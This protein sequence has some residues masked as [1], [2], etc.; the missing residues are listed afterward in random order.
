LCEELTTRTDE[1]LTM[2]NNYRF[3]WVVCVR[4]DESRRYLPTFRYD[5]EQEAVDTAAEMSQRGEPALARYQPEGGQY[6]Y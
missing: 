4:D 3:P 2:A 5:N 6:T 1:D